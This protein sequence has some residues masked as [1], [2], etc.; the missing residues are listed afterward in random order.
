MF[1]LVHISSPLQNAP[2]LCTF[3][4]KLRIITHVRSSKR[5][6]QNKPSASVNLCQSVVDSST[7]L[8]ILLQV[9]YGMSALSMHLLCFQLAIAQSVKCGPFGMLGAETWYL[10]S[11]T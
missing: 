9:M 1:Y 5:S 10:S 7:L 6:L 8:I 2:F 3:A 4:G 11:S